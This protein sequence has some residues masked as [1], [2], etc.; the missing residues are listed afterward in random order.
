[1]AIEFSLVPILH[2]T[3]KIY[4]VYSAYSHSSL[5]DDQELEFLPVLI[6]HALINFKLL[7]KSSTTE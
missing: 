1:M 2:L 4:L 7:I 3:L 6:F 5:E